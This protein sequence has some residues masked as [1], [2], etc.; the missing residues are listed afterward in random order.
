[1]KKIISFLLMLTLTIAL[2]APSFADDD[3]KM[4][5]TI[6]HVYEYSKEKI[7]LEWEGNADLYQIY[8]DGKNV[9]TVNLKT[10]LLSMKP[11]K[12]QIIVV[13]VSYESKNVDTHFEVNVG[14]IAGGSIDL[15]ALGID[16]KDLLQ[17][18]PSAAFKIN[19]TT[20]PIFKA[21]PEVV[22]AYTDFEDRVLL[23]FTDK[24]DSDIYRITIKSGK[25]V[26]YIE[27]NIADKDAEELITKE[28][29]SVTITLDPKY[30]KDHS[31][32]VPELDEKYSFLVQLQ[33][34]PENYVDGEKEHGS[35]LE[36]NDSKAFSYTPYAAWK[37]AAEIVYTSQTAEGQATLRWVHDDNNLGCEYKVLQ[38]EYILGVKKGE[39]EIGKT[40]EKTYTIEDLMNGKYTY[41]VIP[42]LTKEE[43]L[44]SATV[45][46]E[47]SNTWVVAPSLTCEQGEKGEVIL[48]W[49]SPQEVESY[50][51]VVSAGSGSILRFIDLDYKKYTEFDIPA[52][53]GDMEYS[54]IYKD[55]IDPNTGIKLKFE[56][57]GVRHAAD[58]SE[59][60]SAT[61]KQTIIVN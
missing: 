42:T 21:T 55:D 4:K 57:Y 56:I 58:G 10:A 19:Y 1:M 30:L 17:G 27:F 11:G 52:K 39:K 9:A 14:D 22:G 2:C 5:P 35:I 18:T 3:W 15:A 16:P 23:S 46:V 25:D 13:P 36:S 7:A 6:T 49:S 33:K 37:N 31:C 24:Y 48:K 40:K 59:Q 26:N 41:A 50:H 54:F 20:H 34:L 44:P 61:T 53:K 47:I 29:S 45:D 8:V 38:Y 32:L 43:G 12:H 28:K 60:K 51:V